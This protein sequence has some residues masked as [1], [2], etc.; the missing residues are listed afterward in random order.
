MSHSQTGGDASGN[1]HPMMT[2]RRKANEPP[3]EVTNVTVGKVSASTQTSTIADS[4]KKRKKAPLNALFATSKK[5]KTDHGTFTEED[6]DQSS[7]DDESYAEED[8]EHAELLEKYTEKELDYFYNLPMDEQ[9]IIL[10]LEKKVRSVDCKEEPLRFRVLKS[11]EL[12]NRLKAVVLQKLDS[13]AELEPGTGEYAKLANHIN[14]LTRLPLGRY[15]QMKININTSTS[16]R[17][18]AFLANAKALLDDA[19]YGQQS[20]KKQFIM[21][22]AKWVANPSSKGL[23]I[24]IEGP[25]GVGKTTLVQQGLCKALALPYVFVPLGGAND[26]SYLDGHSLT[27]EGSTYGKIAEALMACNYMNPV[28]CFDE[29]DKVADNY[30]GTE[31]FNVLTHLTDYSQNELFQDKYFADTPMDLSRCIMVFTYNDASKIPPVLRDRM[32]SLTTTTYNAA[33]KLK[34]VQDYIFPKVL[35]AHGM[36]A[37]DITMDK[38]LFMTLIHRFDSK[39]LRDVKRSVECIVS[40]VNMLR[41]LPYDM[42]LSNLAD[43]KLVPPDSIEGNNAVQLPFCVT[44]RHAD[45]FLKGS[46]QGRSPKLDDMIQ[47]IYL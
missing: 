8:G 38:E 37:G 34:I 1:C 5:A 2:R 42:Q 17:I 16:D 10:E 28:L 24:G 14:A 43:L 45:A 3:N 41:M 12:D 6:L 30:R 27:Y 25:P 15:K 22:L 7:D 18:G 40:N 21:T 19:V 13:L 39:G 4:V 23:V 46:M 35:D 33:D 26:A 31:I 11:A 47:H 9:G 44:K 32:V 20:I 36:R 29:L